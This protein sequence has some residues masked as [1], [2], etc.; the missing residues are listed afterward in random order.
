VT[1]FVLNP[2]CLTKKLDDYKPAS[3]GGEYVHPPVVHYA[4]LSKSSQPVTLIFRDFVSLLSVYKFLRPEEII[5]H[6]YGDVVG[7]YWEKSKRWRGTH[8]RLMT[9]KRLGSI[10]GKSVKYIAHEADYIRLQALRDIGGLIMDFDVVI[11]N[12]T[13]FKAMQKRSEC[14]ISKE[15][16]FLNVGFMLWLRLQA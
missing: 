12:G 8:V 13:K 1:A 11:V 10:G 6:T 15:E 16:T 5:I 3:N 9:H 14:V 7:A 4:K 2:G